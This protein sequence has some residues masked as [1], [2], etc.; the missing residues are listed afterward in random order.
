MTALTDF[1]AA[2]K[3]SADD[4]S[5]RRVCLALILSGFSAFSALYCVQPILPVF[6]TD[7]NIAP[8]AA[9]LAI[10]ISTM[11]LAVG[12]IFAGP[13]SDAIGR[14]PVILASMTA[15]GCDQRLHM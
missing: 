4:P 15:S 11:A 12:L 9:S 14:K 5:F 8:A 6:A 10:S 13:L 2:Q 1:A 3:I 7:F